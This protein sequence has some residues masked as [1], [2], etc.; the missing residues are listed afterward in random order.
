MFICGC[1]NS[2]C[3]ETCA[4]VL[5]VCVCD[6]GINVCEY[7]LKPVKE[8]FKEVFIPAPTVGIP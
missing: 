2:A 1:V 4:G 3:A 8:I 5:G 6:A 7:T